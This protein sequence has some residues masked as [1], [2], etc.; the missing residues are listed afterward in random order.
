MPHLSSTRLALLCGIVVMAASSGGE[1]AGDLSEGNVYGGVVRR[2]MLEKHVP[3]E[4][5]S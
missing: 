3:R 4:E 2:R 5:G 1:P